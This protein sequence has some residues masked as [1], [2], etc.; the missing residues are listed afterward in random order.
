MK[1]VISTILA[2]VVLASAVLLTS[3]GEKAEC[4]F[5][6]EEYP[7]KKMR[8][9]EVFGDTMYMCDECYGEMSEFFGE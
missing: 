1:K 4:D 2:V 6:N 3:C 7:V 5:C 9:S 8:E